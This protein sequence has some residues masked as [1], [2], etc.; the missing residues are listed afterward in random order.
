MKYVD[1]GYTITIYPEVIESLVGDGKTFY[2]TVR[3]SYVLCRCVTDGNENGTGSTSGAITANVA[4][5]NPANRITVA[6]VRGTPQEYYG[7]S[8]GRGPGRI[9]VK[10]YDYNDIFHDGYG[11]AWEGYYWTASN[12]VEIKVILVDGRSTGVMPVVDGRGK[13]LEPDSPYRA[14]IYEAWGDDINKYKADLN[15]TVP[16]ASHKRTQIDINDANLIAYRD[17]YDYK[18]WNNAGV[19]KYYEP[20]KQGDIINLRFFVAGNMIAA[21]GQESPRWTIFRREDL[22]YW[23]V[24]IGENLEAFEWDG[25]HQALRYLS[26]DGDALYRVIYEDFYFGSPVILEYEEWFAVGN[27]QIYQVEYYRG[28]GKVEYYFK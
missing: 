14:A 28:A 18:M 10:G 8:E 26:P 17:A 22:D 12:G 6:S 13:D 1:A 5:Q 23:W 15:I 27:S 4:E 25:L 3:G 24:S 16:L 2:R 20:Y 7:N 21:V 9:I 19:A 11:I